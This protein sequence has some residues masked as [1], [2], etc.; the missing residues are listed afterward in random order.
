MADLALTT[1]ARLVPQGDRQQRLRQVAAAF[2]AHFIREMMRPSR[3]GAIAEEGLFADSP[4]M[5]Q[6]SDLLH[7][8]LAERA[9][10]GLGLA[11]LIRAQVT[12]Q[13]AVRATAEDPS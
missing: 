2:E 6:Y 1:E 3:E 8:G 11:E 13:D 12:R 9:S 7:D 10:G 4:A 5:R